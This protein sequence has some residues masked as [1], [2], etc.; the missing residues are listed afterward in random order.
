MDKK[1]TNCLYH[2]YSYIMNI[3]I[4]YIE[5]FY[6]IVLGCPINIF[7]LN[8]YFLCNTIENNVVTHTTPL[9][10]NISF[11]LLDPTLSFYLNENLTI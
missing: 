6:L 3:I 10:G 5:L 2:V 1:D 8:E 4:L 11:Q 9:E 7:K